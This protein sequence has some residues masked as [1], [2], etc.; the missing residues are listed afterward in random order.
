MLESSSPH[1]PHSVCR[2]YSSLVFPFIHFSF[3]ASLFPQFLAIFSFLILLLSWL[4]M[5]EQDISFYL[6]NSQSSYVLD[7]PTFV[8][9]GWCSS[10]KLCD[11]KS[12]REDFCIPYTALLEIP[13]CD[14]VD[15]EGFSGKVV[16]TVC[17][18]THGLRLPLCHPICDFLDLLRIALAQLHSYAWRTLFC[19]CIVF[20]MGL[21]PTRKSTPI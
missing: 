9:Y 14:C 7:V 1:I 4:S 12:L 17:A 19:S 8:G 13:E 5:A 11:L 20:R 21:E 18:L 2:L 15:E 10:L 6:T 3:L 16:L